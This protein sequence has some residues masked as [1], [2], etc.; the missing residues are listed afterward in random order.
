MK[1]VSACL[2]LVLLWTSA[3]CAQTD[4]ARPLETSQAFGDYRV[5]YNVF[6]STFVTPEV[7]RLHGLTRAGNRVLI[8]I[9]LTRTREGET[10]L[11]LPAR[12]TGTATNL[13]QQQR[14][15]EFVT[16]DEG[17]A[18]YYLA[19]LRHTREEIIH[20]TVNVQ[21]E[22]GDQAFPVRFTRTLYIDK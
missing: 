19:S 21:P 18:V 13:L 20:F 16:V 15:L 4:Q 3:T 9:S 12:V 11:G 8:N 6:N 1:T 10:S 2:A 7:A 14:P 5:H 22:G 17:E